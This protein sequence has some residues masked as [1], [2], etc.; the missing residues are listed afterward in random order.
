MFYKTAK[1]LIIFITLLFSQTNWTKYANNPVMVKTNFLT[2]FYAIGQPTVIMENDTFKMWYC[3]AGIDHRGRILYAYSVDGI[4]WT[5]YQSGAIVL[6]IGSA[7]EW[8]S[9][10]LDTP[11]IVRTPTDYKLYYYGDVVD[12]FPP[13]S[14]AIGLA[15]SANGINWTKHPNNPIFTKGESLSWE[16]HWIE[17]PA[18]LYDE[19]IYKM[20]Y[21]GVPYDW[22]I[23]IG[24]AT[25]PDG[26]VW[27]KYPN[28]PV[29]DVGAPGSWDDMWVAVPAVI[30]RNN[31]F[32]MW[33]SALSE[34]DIAT[35]RYDTIRIGFA[36][37]YDGVNWTKYPEPVLTTLTPPHNPAVD[38]NG[39]WAPDVVFD[40]TNY[41]MWYE[42]A[43]GFCYATAPLSVMESALQ[44]V[45][46]TV[47]I[48]PN[49][50][51]N[52][53]VINCAGRF[54]FKIYDVSGRL[55]RTLTGQDRIVWDGKN[56]HR[57]KLQSGIYF[58]VLQSR[59]YKQT[60]K[61]VIY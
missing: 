21:T 53:T 40:G 45:L 52:L 47:K 31:R 3:A 30:K 55:L 41:R 17:S 48:S 2:E 36:T 43:A 61:L 37:S 29:L 26:V 34:A 38:S 6:N 44:T 50:F 16:G 19:G 59:G 24:Y 54:R 4:N 57:Q 39:P 28:N 13:H 8:D 20:W 7:G 33:Y 51:R 56:E 11:E 60:Y 12:T 14:A 46:S 42:T 58:G 15:T 5:K 27:T 10:W 9:K 32:E 49:P 1:L 22:R 23:R 35:G 25:S 18:V